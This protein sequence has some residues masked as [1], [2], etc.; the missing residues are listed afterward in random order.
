MRS[1]I[2][3]ESRNHYKI[4][5]N[6]RELVVTPF[7]RWCEAHE[8]RVQNS[9]DEL[10][11]RVRAHDRQADSVRKM[12]SQY[13]N[14]CRLVEDLE[15]EDKLAFQDPKN[16]L[17]QSP[18]SQS[19]PTV[20]LSEPDGNDEDEMYEIGDET[21]TNEQIKK[22]LSDML[23][24]ITLGEIKVP[25]LGTY[26]NVSSGAD[27]TDYIQKQLN[28]NSLS[29]AERIGQDL[30]SNGFLRLVGNVGNTFANSSKMHYQWRPKVF[31]MTDIP[32]KKKPL[33]R[34]GTGFSMDGVDSQ[35]V[36][37]VSEYLAGWNPLSQAHPNETPPDKL[38]REAREA[39]ERYKAA[40]RKLDSLR[41]ELE[42]SIIDHLKFME[43]CEL[44]RLRAIKA[45]ILDFSGAIS[46]VIPSLRSTVD[47]MMLFQ[48][49]VQP[50]A[51]LRY[52]LENYRTGPFVPRVITYE[53][54]Y[55]SV[56]GMSFAVILNINAY[57]T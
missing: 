55:N 41:C 53:N 43:R 21:Y 17:N 50:V 12:R 20:R 23:K 3:Q 4:A 35:F 47:N 27:I 32:E 36:N 57:R 15:E 31:Q 22:I 5:S 42:E 14:K 8:A 24:T 46:N 6:V 2:S 33:E 52:M 19:I 10:Q 11:S 37:G 28:A 51:D 45:V 18:R 9:Q 56:D 25:I 26:M 49:T 1:E 48:E 30:V 38:R 54:Y 13:Y 7:G 44:D 16:E 40:V 39:D 34:S 29:Y